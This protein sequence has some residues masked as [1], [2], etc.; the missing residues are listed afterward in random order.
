[1]YT[2]VISTPL[3]NMLIRANVQAVY[4]LGFPDLIPEILPNTIS[5]NAALQ[6]N[7]Y[8]QGRRQHFDFTFK[9]EGTEFQQTVWKELLNIEPGKP[10]SYSALSKKMNN[11]LAIRAIAAAN[12]KNNLMIVVPCH[13]VIGH[14]GQLV[15]YSGG[16][17]RKKWLLEHE[18]QLTKTGQS[19]LTFK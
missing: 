12:G 3:G 1:M 17:W 19:F 15:G 11:H 18:V 7:E 8:F 9:Q 10:I 14:D 6:L 16:L 13:R 4:Y 5:E 2:S